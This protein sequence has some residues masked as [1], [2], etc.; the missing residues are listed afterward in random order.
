M[1]QPTLQNTLRSALGKFVGTDQIPRFLTQL[2]HTCPF[3]QIYYHLKWTSLIIDLS[4]W[5]IMQGHVLPCTDHE[6][7]QGVEME[8]TKT[9][10]TDTP[11]AFMLS[12]NSEEL[13][14]INRLCLA[15]ERISALYTGTAISKPVSCDVST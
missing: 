13:N 14:K 15:T 9:V 5:T 4:K 1:A 7:L 2:Y 3:E 6:A 11:A 10:E 8:W 12:M